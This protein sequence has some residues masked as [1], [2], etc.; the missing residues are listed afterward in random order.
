VTSERQQ[1]HLAGAEQERGRWARELHDETLQRL[2]ALQIALSSAQ[3][4]GG[5]ETLEL[6]IDEAR[7]LLRSEIANL[8][9]L[10]TELRPP[11]LDEL[12]LGAALKALAERTSNLGMEVD[13]SVGIVSEQDGI[14]TA[15]RA[16][17]LET[18][19]YRLVQEALTNAAEHGCAKRT[20]VEVQD[21]DGDV[22]V[23]VRD[24]GD[25]FDTSSRTDGFGLLGMRERV[26]MV[27]GSL[28]IK[29]G[30]DGTTVNAVLPVRHESPTRSALQGMRATNGG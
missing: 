3:R 28:E 16:P 25:G 12:G 10:I 11:T 24:D 30:P 5:L 29:S 6:A 1:E 17:E 18:I 4:A 13:V 14:T 15:R 21:R 19:V 23:S 27:D 7:A 2:A 9:A 20:A 26:E 22:H 8:R